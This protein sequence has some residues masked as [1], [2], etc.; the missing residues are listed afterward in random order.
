[1]LKRV[2]W[3]NKFETFEWVNFWWKFNG[4]YSSFRL[5]PRFWGQNNDNV[6]NFDVI[7]DMILV[8][9]R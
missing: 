9:G 4:P 7:P 1:M 2:V 5:K 6:H 8:I 3:N